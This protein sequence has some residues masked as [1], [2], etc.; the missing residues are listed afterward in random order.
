M[1]FLNDNS[2]DIF[3]PSGNK[4][5]GLGALFASTTEDPRSLKYEAPKKP[6]ED[7]DV[8]QKNTPTVVNAFLWDANSRNYKA[9]GKAGLAIVVP[10]SK[11]STPGPLLVLFRSKQQPL[12]K[13]DLADVR[14]KFNIQSDHQAGFVDA[15]NRAWSVQ[16][17][18]GPQLLEFTKKLTA[19]RLS[20]MKDD[21]ETTFVVF[22]AGEGQP[23]KMDNLVTIDY[24]LWPITASGSTGPIAIEG[25]KGDVTIQKSG[26][27]SC[28]VD[29]KLGSSFVITASRQ[30]AL[31]SSLQLDL[32]TLS[33]SRYVGIYVTIVEQLQKP[34]PKVQ[35]EK[36]KV[37][38]RP[39]IQGQMKKNESEDDDGALKKR[40]KG[41]EDK[42]DR[43]L[44]NQGLTTSDFDDLQDKLKAAQRES[45]ELRVQL[46]EKAIKVKA[47]HQE[48]YD[49]LARQI[50][51]LKNEKGQHKVQIEAANAKLKA[52]D[53]D[54]QRHV[55]R[56]MTAVFKAVKAD[57][58]RHEDQKLSGDQVID[59]L[60]QN[61]RQVTEMYFESIP[62]DKPVSSTTDIG[63]LP[64]ATVQPLNTL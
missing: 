19:V 2:D 45:D 13:L 32:E 41:I 59:C 11:D 57:V 31:E 17:P 27:T 35:C 56:V 7:T 52:V 28:L 23:V 53:Q 5:K 39:E 55:K 61:I 4:S 1:D 6:S 24:S 43:V 3:E 49:R 51:E 20:A 58:G 14:L 62:K 25:K 21:Q 12:S 42:L 46:N 44:D 34:L 63:D 10:G 30:S 15:N 18:K 9:I 60:A 26:W 29:A 33:D 36:P 40:L 50:E 37:K 64:V 54:I 16:F 38:A 48:E 8:Q 47:D 22:K